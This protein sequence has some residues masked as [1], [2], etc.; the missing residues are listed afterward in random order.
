LKRTQPIERQALA[1]RTFRSFK[2]WAAALLLA[3]GASAGVPAARAA[4]LAIPP[5][6]VPAFAAPAALLAFDQPA[7][8]GEAAP[9]KPET[10]SQEEQEKKFRHSPAIEWFSK[11]FHLDVETTAQIF[12]YFN[13]AVIVLAVGIPLFKALPALFRRRSARLRADIE[14]AQAKTADAN[15][16]LTAVEQKLAGLDAEISLIRKQVEEDMRADEARSKAAIEEETARIVAAAE[17]EIVMAGA[18]AERGLRQFAAQLAVDRALSTLTLDA[19]TDRALIAEFSSDLV[20]GKRPR[21]PKG[22][23]N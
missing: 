17:H 5:F 4:S 19:E 20:G 9:G 21:T 10:Q 12:E 14:V 15:A 1:P 23:Q 2:L 3:S 8:R 22:E 16:R 11:L 13:F 18:Q 7:L 6:P